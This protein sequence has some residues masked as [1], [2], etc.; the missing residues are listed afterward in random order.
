VVRHNPRVL[1]D[2]LDPV[3][4]P[5]R[6]SAL[7]RRLREQNDPGARIA[8]LAAGGPYERYLA[9]TAAAALGSRPVVVRAL[10]DPDPSVRAEAARQAHRL[11]WAT[12]G[13]LLADAPPVLR[14]LIL[15]LLRKRPGSGDA[16]IDLV[17]DRYGDREAVVVLAAC[18]PETV[19]RLLPDLAGLVGSWK[20]LA[21]R[22]GA[23]ILDW[24]GD[25]LA[26]M[27][28]PDW[29]AFVAPVGACARAEPERVLDLLERHAPG[30][31]PDIDLA[32]LAARFPARVAAL[33]IARGPA[34]A[35]RY[36]TF[37]VL[38]HLRTLGVDDLVALDALNAGILELL[39]PDRRE[40]VYAARPGEDVPWE[41]RVELLPERTR[42][43]EV[44]RVLALPQIAADEHAT[45]RWSRYL[46]AA[47]ALPVLDRAARD[48]IPYSRG[49]AYRWMVGV[50]RREPAALPDVL[51][52]LLRLRNE[53]EAV[54]FPMLEALRALIPQLV[55]SAAPM[56][57]AITDASI[58]AR[59]FSPRNR[60][61]LVELAYAALAARDTGPG[62][63]DELTRWALGMIARLPIPWYLETPLRPGQEHLITAALRKRITADTDELF[64]LARLLEVRARHVP[65]LQDL[66]HRA[67]APSGPAD[68]RE[69][70]VKL[71]LDDPRTRAARAAELLRAD[72]SAARLAP[73]WRELT[74]YSTTLLDPTLAEPTLVGPPSHIRRWTPRQQRAYAETLAAVAADT[75]LEQGPRKA[76]LKNLARVPVAGRELLAGFLDA[77]EVPIAEAALGALAW[78]DRPDEALPVLLGYA[79][80]ERARTALP[81]ADRAARFVSAPAL[82]ALLRG[83]LLAPPSSPIGVTSRKAAVRLTRYGPPESEELLAEVWHTPGAHPDVRAVVIAALRSPSP[84][85]IAWEIFTEAASSAARAEVLALLAVSAQE[86]SEPDCRRFASLVVTV[87]ASPHRQL[88]QDAFCQL[89]KWIRWV[90]DAAG[91]VVAALADPDFTG[92]R[93]YWPV[94]A[95]A[96]LVEALL[97]HPVDPG[98][99]ALEPLFDRLVV[100]DREDPEPGTP[101]RDRPA[102]RCLTRIVGDAS[103]WARALRRA[104]P[105]PVREAARKLASHPAFLGDG[106][107]LLT[108]LAGPHPAPLAEV[109]DLVAARPALAVR[110][111]GQLADSRVSADELEDVL[112]AARQ[113]ADRTDLAGGL[114]ALALV[115]AAGKAQRWSE[116]CQETLRQLRH[117]PHPDVADASYRQ[118]MER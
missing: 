88:S 95:L 55:P 54:R 69:E 36:L 11:G 3:P 79:G 13:E 40:E 2:E 100:R 32:P 80:G 98:R 101:D 89:P 22:H 84:S 45:L 48:P 37:R 99:S 92:P 53:R 64:S 62:D 31:L 86:L 10:R 7:L 94:P 76:A 25:S 4:Y 118:T 72:P 57:T 38:P 77:P 39:P 56:L 8:E 116:P 27:T 14:H 1:S 66:L 103:Q 49:E 117:H 29:S 17:R 35:W 78:T 90:S 41:G 19:A 109:A 115:A 51:R 52:R 67:T 81:A 110:L 34:D 50:A 91:L 59:D 73:V 106:A 9:V 23:V 108:A 30:S 105:E 33:V 82:L 20:V 112:A 70:A 58:E 83:V 61:A 71:W 28:R 104:D 46:P 6:I 47:E 43:R 65:E 24:V 102:R 93:A 12:A 113:L 74:G 87:C 63:G 60:E 96:S 16:V 42:L 114:F 26:A 44:R 68:V 21:R 5:K 18:T 75:D 85:P 15:R 111:A 97:D 107:E